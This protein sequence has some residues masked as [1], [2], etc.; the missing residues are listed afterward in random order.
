MSSK[1][2]HKDIELYTDKE[3][4]TGC[5]N[6]DR[7]CQEILYRKHAPAMYKVCMNY[8]NS[9]DEAM[10][11]LQNGFITVFNDIHKFRFEGPLAGWIRRVIVYKTIDVLR[12]EK[13]YQEVI[14]SAEIPA[15]HEAEEFEFDHSADK[16]KRIISIVNELPA[17]AGLVLKL[18]AIEGYSHQEIADILDISVGTSKSQLNRARSLVKDAIGDRE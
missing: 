8:A 2:N 10:E 13:R 1:G 12:K 18:Y 6:D 15:Y 9:R 14:S 4:V 5:V 17:K 11:F 16:L 7:V 3:L